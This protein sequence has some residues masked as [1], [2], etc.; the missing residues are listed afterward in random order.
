MRRIVLAAA[1]LGLATVPCARADTLHVAADAQTSSTQPTLRFGLFP[2]MSVRQGGGGPVMNSYIRFDLSAFPE[3]PVV[4]KAMLRIFVFGVVTPGTIEVLPVMVPWQESTITAATSPALGPAVAS[5]AVQG[6]DT[7]QFVQV[8]VTGVVQDWARGFSDNRGLA[9]RGVGAVNVIFDSKEAI[10]TSHAPELEVVVGGVGEQGPTGPPG[11]QGPPGPPGPQGNPGPQGSQGPTGATGAQGPPGPPGPPGSGGLPAG[12]AVMGVP[13]DPSLLAAG[14]TDTGIVSAEQWRVVNMWGF[15]TRA[16]HTAVWTGSRMLFWG[17]WSGGGASTNTGFQ[18]LGDNGFFSI[19]LADA[20]TARGAHT[21]VWT[22]SRM[23]VW[24]GQGTA[25]Y[26]NT[27]GRYD[28]TTNSWMPITTIGAPA[29]RAY[30]TA[31]WTGSRM[32]VWGGIGAGSVLNTG[33][34]YDPSTDSWRPITTAGAPTARTRHSAVWTGSRMLVWGGWEDWDYYATNTGAV[35]DPATDSWIPITTSGAPTARGLHTAVWTGS[36]MLVWGGQGDSGLGSGGGE[37]D[38]AADAWRSMGLA[39]DVPPDRVNH[40]A[41]WTGSRM[42]IW[43]GQNNSGVFDSGGAYDPVR[44][45]WAGITQD[46]PHPSSRCFHTA[47]W[48][49]S[50]M[51]IWGGVSGDPDDSGG[52][53]L[54]LHLF[55][56]N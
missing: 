30:H 11:T 17:G 5:F 24:G 36:R 16:S 39:G 2:A 14:Y 12:A 48:T 51:I 44:M 9:L 7:L 42:L 26:T 19:S 54:R 33:G 34:E 50:R 47:V 3:N 37:Y 13:G 31:V 15:P 28:P 56:R 45:E 40:T 22:G 41:V 21:A 52:V 4:Q 29:A 53:Y 23:L 43:G 35:Y 20:P 10:V 25:G 55:L 32:L 8:D 38:L 18:L 46:F 49:G 27:G 6:S 1:V